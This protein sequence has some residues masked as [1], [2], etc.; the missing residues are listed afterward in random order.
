MTPE[1]RIAS[2]EWSLDYRD[3]LAIQ[4]TWFPWWIGWRMWPIVALGDDE[5]MR[6]TVVVGPLCFPLWRCRCKDCRAR[7]ADLVRHVQADTWP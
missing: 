6:R 1:E 2:Y 3:L 4:K 5:W 7:Y